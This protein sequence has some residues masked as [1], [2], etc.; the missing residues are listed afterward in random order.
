MTLSP[1]GLH[2]YL[3][4]SHPSLLRVYEAEPPSGGL[5]LVQ[6]MLTSNMPT[7]VRT[8]APDMVKSTLPTELSF[9][10]LS[11]D[12]TTLLASGTDGLVS[13]VRDVDTGQ[14]SVVSQV[15]SCSPLPSQS[16][17]TEELGPIVLFSHDDQWVFM[18]ATDG[19]L[20]FPMTNDGG[21]VGPLGMP[22]TV[23]VSSLSD[24][25]RIPGQDIMFFAS[26]E[27][28]PFGLHVLTE[29]CR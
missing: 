17:P 23:N 2:L 11:S 6:D 9:V 7:T 20:L 27:H 13:Y 8:D 15:A 1:D 4:Y 19:L 14:L 24:F 26:T 3:A 5:R 16:D 12:G 25:A 29:S 28:E 18:M 22:T 21:L 10:T